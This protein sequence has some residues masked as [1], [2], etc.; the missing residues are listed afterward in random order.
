MANGY[1]DRKQYAA[2]ADAYYEAA[3]RYAEIGDVQV[4]KILRTQGQRYET[5][6]NLYYNRNADKAALRKSNYLGKRLEPMYGA[7]LGAFIDREDGVQGTFTGYNGQVHRDVAEFN[8]KVGKRHAVFFMY[9]RYGNPFPAE[10]FAHLKE[11]GVAAQW[12]ML[13]QTLDEVQDNDYLRGLAREAAKTGV[14]VFIRFGGEMNGAWVPYH[15]NP[16]SYKQKFRLVA[17]VFHE[18]CPK[19]AMVWCPNEIPEAQIPAYYPGEDAVDWVGINF[20]SVLYNDNNPSRPVLWRNPSDA[21]DYIYRNY[22]DRHPILIGEYG[23][24]HESSADGVARPDFAAAKLGQLYA[25]LPRRYPR[26]KA[27]HYFSMNALRYAAEGRRLNNYALL[28]A[29][30]PQ[31]GTRYTELVRSSYFLEQVESGAC[32]P[33]ETAPL[34]SGAV[35]SGRVTISAGAKTYEL[36]P[37]VTIAAGGRELETFT[38][39]GDY[40]TSLDTTMLPNGPLTLTVT[41]ADSDGHIAGRESVAVRIANGKAGEK[42]PIPTPTPNPTP[43]KEAHKNPIPPAPKP[44]A[45]SPKPTTFTLAR[46]LTDAAVDAQQ[47]SLIVEPNVS[48]LT[49][50]KGLR[51]SIEVGAEGYLVVILTD[52]EGAMTPLYPRDPK[53]GADGALVKAGQNVAIPS[54]PRRTLKP[55]TPGDFRVRAFLLPT[56]ESADALLAAFAQSGGI[57]TAEAARS[58]GNMTAA[59]TSK[60]YRAERQVK[61]IAP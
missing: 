11:N 38:E 7:Y 43:Y 41:V 33:V 59:P 24:T 21:L 58:A 55:D 6:V 37:K 53:V 12:V 28:D 60:V 17:R 49:L 32:A 52:K 2:A 1:V 14:P 22:S 30:A 34:G 54:N 18:E 61:V 4:A 3:R 27:I 15:G 45:P 5:R 9:T 44:P 31:I 47:V 48:A 26:V 46:L 36:R 19:A 42:K 50:G 8:R 56:K 35:L 51:L 39:P 29:N 13:P 20:Y 16:E 57:L 23:A 10:W 40:A 25:S